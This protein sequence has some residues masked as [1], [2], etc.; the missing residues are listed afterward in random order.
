VQFS[1]A[2]T[3]VKQALEALPLYTDGEDA[4][5]GRDFEAARP[6]DST[7][8]SA[9]LE[10]SAASPAGPDAREALDGP[11]VSR[12]DAKA[13][14]GTSE[15]AGKRQRQ[16]GAANTEREEDPFGLEAMLPSRANAGSDPFGL[17]EMIPDK[18]RR[19]EEK[20]KR[21]RE[22][23]QRSVREEVQAK[24][25]LAGRRAVVLECLKAA[26]SQYKY[27]W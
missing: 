23:E 11:S 13:E 3:K 12:G 20:A 6:G 26:Y 14:E 17:D 7:A 1:R 9:P 16:S 19:K 2:T 10:S 8:A 24:E 15:R 18:T 22:E 27:T 21:K 4:T 25:L 5:V